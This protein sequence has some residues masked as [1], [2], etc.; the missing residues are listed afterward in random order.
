MSRY[1]VIPENILS[2]R[3]HYTTQLKTFSRNLESNGF[4]LR[5]YY[6][7]RWRFLVFFWNSTLQF[8][9]RL[10]GNNSIFSSRK[11]T[12]LSFSI[13]KWHANR[14]QIDILA[15]QMLCFFIDT[16]LCLCF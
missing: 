13:R 6:G 4:T 3:I 9:G 2:C 7:I 11:K 14:A 5:N 10:Y 15:Y 16:Y 8:Y 1:V 12:I